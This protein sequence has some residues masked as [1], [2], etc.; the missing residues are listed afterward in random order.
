[1]TAGHPITLAVALTLCL[2]ATPALATI[3]VSISP[4]AQIVPI[5]NGTTTVDIVA[6]IPASDAIIGW[7]LDLGLIGSSISINSISINAALFDIVPAAD[8]DGLAAIV[9]FDQPALNGLVTLATITFALDGLGVT[10]LGLADDRL[11][12]PTEGFVLDPTSP[13]TFADVLY[14]GGSINVIPEPASIVL[15]V[16][17]AASS[18]RR[19]R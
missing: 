7:G 16:L 3:D 9:P 12:D 8:G 13:D 2:V 15:I 17:G 14:T 1:M 4:A 19:R 10:Q 6:N 11:T 5:T 18:L